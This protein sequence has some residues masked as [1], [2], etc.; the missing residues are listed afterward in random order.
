MRM[1][2]M[3]HSKHG[4]TSH[5]TCPRRD[6]ERT[7]DVQKSDVNSISKKAQLHSPETPAARV[8]ASEETLE[9]LEL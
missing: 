9:G 8:L 1:R 2:H 5:R 7:V 4:M 3:E 6:N